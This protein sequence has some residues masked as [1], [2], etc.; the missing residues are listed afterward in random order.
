MVER[1]DSGANELGAAVTSQSRTNTNAQLRTHAAAQDGTSRA[2]AS[3]FGTKSALVGG[4]TG[5]AGGPTAL[6]RG[7][8]FG[9]QFSTVQTPPI[10]PTPLVTCVAANVCTPPDP[11][12]GNWKSCWVLK[13][14]RVQIPHPPRLT[15]SLI[16]I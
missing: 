6:R 1:S 12:K 8:Q 10:V 15:L 14:S 2:P 3:A 13:P 11:T 5:L 4:R 9:A 16:H 7:S